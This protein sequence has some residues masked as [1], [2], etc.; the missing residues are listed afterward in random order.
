MNLYEIPYEYQTLCPPHSRLFLLGLVI[1]CMSF[2][3][4]S[5]EMKQDI[6]AV[7]IKVW[8]KSSPICDS[9]AAVLPL[10]QENSS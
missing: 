9:L 7:N 1:Q 8:C 5:Q 10:T 3:V 2:E 6:T 4:I